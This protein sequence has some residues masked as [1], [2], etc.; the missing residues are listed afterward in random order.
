MRVWQQFG[1]C[2]HDHSV[3]VSSASSRLGGNPLFIQFHYHP[4][5]YSH[6][7]ICFLRDLQVIVFF[8]QKWDNICES[9]SF[10]SKNG[11]MYIYIYIYASSH[12]TQLEWNATYF[13]KSSNLCP[14]SS[15]GSDLTIVPASRNRVPSAGKGRTPTET[16]T[17]FRS[18]HLAVWLGGRWYFHKIEFIELLDQLCENCTRRWRPNED[19]STSADFSL[20]NLSAKF[21]KF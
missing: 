18:K 13:G 19:C 3:S 9:L 16:A 10:S 12:S 14:N 5:R 21:L 8:L 2:F 15:T 1:L 7:F 11:T 6:A 20:L 4:P 17:L